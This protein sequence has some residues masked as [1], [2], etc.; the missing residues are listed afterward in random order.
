MRSAGKIVLLM[1]IIAFAAMAW[2]AL[3]NQSGK[4]SVKVEPAGLILKDQKSIYSRLEAIA[5]S[6]Y[7]DDYGVLRVYGSVKNLAPDDCIYAKLKI[8]VRDEGNKL[9]KTLEVTVKNIKPDETKSY[10]VN[11]GTGLEGVK[12][13]G[14]IIESGFAAR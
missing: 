10:D 3:G 2:A 1:A 6:A 14:N 11:G 4:Q 13:E 7:V 5:P 9:K 8:E 12:V